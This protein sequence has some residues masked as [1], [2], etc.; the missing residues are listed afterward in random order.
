VKIFI[1][2]Y[3]RSGSTALCYKLAETNQ[4]EFLREPLT[5]CQFNEI[6]SVINDI[7]AV[8]TG[9]IKFMSHNFLGSESY[10]LINWHEADKIILAKRD[11]LPAACVS[12]YAA[13][14]VTH[15]WQGK[16]NLENKSLGKFAVSDTFMFDFALFIAKFNE[17]EKFLLDSGLAVESVV[18]SGKLIECSDVFPLNYNYKEQCINYTEVENKFK[19]LGL[20]GS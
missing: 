10:K 7:N 3:P 6:P 11:S 1:L 9:V 5:E 18:Y 20:Y 13:M 16:R 12:N 17:V 19:E 2:G 15:Q 8:E 4:I 14:F